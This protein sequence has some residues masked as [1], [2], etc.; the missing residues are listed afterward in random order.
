MSPP[1]PW[2]AGQWG[3]VVAWRAS[4]RFPHALLLRGP[5]G[6]G[7]A[8]FADRVANSLVCESPGGRAEPCGDCR[9]CRLY[10]AGSHPD[11]RRVE[12]EEGEQVVRVDQVRELIAWSTLSARQ[13]TY[14]VALLSPADRMNRAAA[15]SLLKTLEE[16]SRDT[17]F[18]LISHLPHL[19]PA[20]VRSR[21][22]SVDFCPVETAEAQGWL[23]AQIEG[24]VPVERLLRIASGAPIRAR[25]LA[26]SGALESRAELLGH[27]R[28]LVGGERSPVTAAAGWHS[29]GLGEIAYWTYSLAS[30]LVRIKMGGNEERLVHGDLADE[31]RDLSARV[32]IRLLFSL[33][34]QSLEAIRVLEA[35]LNLNPQFLLEE[36]A[37]TWAGVPEPA[38]GPQASA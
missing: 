18:L 36:M 6:L 29:V 1:L 35:R 15:N 8:R 26:R 10:R 32:E 38:R 33:L 31:L 27:V 13:G 4:E 2:Q 5:S 20:T 17:V 24:K 11:V 14:A 16:P 12:P 7:K 37:M 22:Q 9:G 21:C 19:L 34:D 30:D 23:R 28:G 25:E 3:R